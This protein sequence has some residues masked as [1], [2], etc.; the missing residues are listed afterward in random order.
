MMGLAI[1]LISRKA[2][3][4]AGDATSGPIPQIAFVMIATGT[5]DYTFFVT[6][7]CLMCKPS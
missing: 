3:T 5:N 1:A 7:S 2:T 4:A 6:P